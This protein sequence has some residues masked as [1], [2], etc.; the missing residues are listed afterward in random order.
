MQVLRTRCTKTSAG[1]ELS[2]GVDVPT[3]QLA[4]HAESST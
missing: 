4:A 3:V 2:Y 1:Q